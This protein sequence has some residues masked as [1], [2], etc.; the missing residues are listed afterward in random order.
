MVE[1]L[2][3]IRACAAVF[4]CGCT[5]MV[6]QP[7]INYR[8]VVNSAT[9]TPAGLTGGEIARGSVFSIFGRNIGP[10]NLAQV[11]VFPLPAALANVSIKITQGKTSVDAFPLIVTAGQVNAIMPSNAPLGR[12]SVQLTFNGAVSN[13]VAATVVSSNFGIFSVN[14]AGFGPGILQ[15][16]VTP[17]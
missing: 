14:S 6:A 12:V 4:A 7:Y 15:N 2:M 13:P 3:L 10:A 1:S 17:E 9:F 8:G 16:F 11:S 5:M